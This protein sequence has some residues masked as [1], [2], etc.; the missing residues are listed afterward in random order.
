MFLQLGAGGMGLA[1]RVGALGWIALAVLALL[2]P[3]RAAAADSTVPATLS[4]AEATYELRVERVQRAKGIPA[5]FEMVKKD[6]AANPRPYAKAWYAKFLLFGAESDLKDVA[7]P[8]RGF[9]LAKESQAEG[10]VLGTEL[11]G[12]A[13]LNGRGTPYK[14]TPQG[15]KLIREAAERGSATASRELADCYF[16][17]RGMSRDIAK[18]I[19]WART[20]CAR[21]N[22]DGLWDLAGWLEDPQFTQPTQPATALQL[23]F[24]ILQFGD[25]AALKVLKER[26]AKGDVAAQKYV[27]LDTVWEREV[28]GTAY[29]VQV[30]A[31]V[32]WLESHAAPDDQPVQL[33]LAE[34][35]MERLGPIY[36]PKAAR[37]KLTRAAAAGS[38]DA[39]ALLAMMAWRGID[40]KTDGAAAIAMWRELAGRGWRA[41][42]N[43]ANCYMEGIGVEVNYHLAA[44]YYGILARKGYF[45]AGEMRDRALAYVKD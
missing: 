10:C 43:L 19:D 44:K 12:L 30:R 37:E 27:Y 35:M 39:R 28:G 22:V 45:H 6:F 21:G 1:R 29:P 31:A 11:V 9:A 41:Q 5:A 17:G 23:Y 36:D 14:S 7:D 4:D 20:A 8:K 32:K 15:V 3:G 38:D 40:Q 34:M 2:V 13:W 26:A 33:I 24:E 25:D 16:G 18:A 42:F